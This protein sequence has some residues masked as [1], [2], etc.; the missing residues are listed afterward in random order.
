MKFAIVEE[1]DHKHVH[2][3]EG[4]LWEDRWK[5]LKEKPL[6]KS[7]PPPMPRDG[8]RNGPHQGAA[9]GP[10][11]HAQRSWRMSSSWFT[12]RA[13]L[14]NVPAKHTQE[15]ILKSMINET[16]C[17]SPEFDGRLVKSIENLCAFHLISVYF[18]SNVN[19]KTNFV[20]PLNRNN[21]L[22]MLPYVV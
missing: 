17:W 21:I 18:V 22:L 3:D 13:V 16:T 4:Q 1:Q 14:I 7:A 19:L 10:Q 15:M 8:G 2:D 5:G 11:L 12:C 9:G 6:R 20:M